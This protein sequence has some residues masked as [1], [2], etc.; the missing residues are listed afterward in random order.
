MVKIKNL[1]LVTTCVT[2]AACGAKEQAATQ[3]AQDYSLL[4]VE[5][6]N[7]TLEQKYTASIRGKQDIKIIPRVSG[8]L[9]KINVKEGSKVRKGE[10]M[11]VIDQ[12]PYIAAANAAKASVAI[13][14]AN[15]ATAE[16]SYKGKEKLFA[17]KVISE[18]DLQLAKNSVESA[19]AQLL[20]A[21]ANLMA[22]NNNLSYTEVKSPSNGVV[23]VLPYRLG[24]LVG[25]TTVNGLTIVSDNS[26]MYV[27]F[28][29]SEG[30]VLDL[31]N[32]YPSMDSA[33]VAM[34]EITLELNNRTEYPYTGKVESI[35]GVVDA[36][37]GSVSLRSK[38][39]NENGKLISG[40]AGSIVMPY[41]KENIYLIPQESTYEIQNMT[42]VYKVIDGKAVSSVV[43]IDKVNDG[44]NYIVLDGIAEGDVIIAK[45][46]G[47]VREG[48]QVVSK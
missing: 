29:M 47:L 48:T 34:P 3:A 27:Y 37:T 40:G 21:E 10:V 19:K 4:T 28:S 33:I 24:D 42:Y 23:G 11:F 7:V 15:V 36:A 1:L 26:D 45:G 12:E 14:K 2:L 20:Q 13:A 25:A 30:N 31:I 46:A 22:A 17:S 41:T 16:L 35:S 43:E 38:F 32:E 6:S 9:T 44:K 8:Y 5:K 39:P 18:F